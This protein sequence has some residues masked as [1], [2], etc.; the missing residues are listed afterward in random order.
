MN[1]CLFIIFVALLVIGLVINVYVLWGA[2]VFYLVN[3]LEALANGNL[4][5][6]N[7]IKSFRDF[8]EIVSQLKDEKPS[9]HFNVINYK[10][11]P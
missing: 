3:I 7:E 8:K 2:L 10:Q 4:E 9:I 1:L 6:F 5:R 11:I